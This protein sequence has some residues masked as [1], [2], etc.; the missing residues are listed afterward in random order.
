[1]EK[2]AQVLRVRWV[3]LPGPPG[4]PGAPERGRRGLQRRC[5]IHLDILD[6][7]RAEDAL[8]PPRGMW[9][10]GLVDGEHTMRDCSEHI[11]GD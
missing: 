8:M 1:V 2:P 9:G 10:W 4:V 11:Q 7:M 6:D 5:I 3:T